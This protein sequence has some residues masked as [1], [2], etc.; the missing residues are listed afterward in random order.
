MRSQT[1]SAHG[2]SSGCMNDADFL[3][4]YGPKQGRGQESQLRMSCTCSSDGWEQVLAVFPFLSVDYG[5]SRQLS[6]R[7]LTRLP[8]IGAAAAGLLHVLPLAVR[9]MLVSIFTGETAQ[10]SMTMHADQLGRECFGTRSAVPSMCG[11]SRCTDSLQSS[12][13]HRV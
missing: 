4:V 8:L 3:K 7:R 12:A 11:C 5:S 9:C 13:S 2:C 10:D 1:G 6:I